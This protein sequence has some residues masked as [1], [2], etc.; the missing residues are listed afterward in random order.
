MTGFFRDVLDRIDVPILDEHVMALVEAEV[1][2]V[3]LSRLGTTDATL[4]EDRE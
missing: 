2:D 1:A 3:D 4:L